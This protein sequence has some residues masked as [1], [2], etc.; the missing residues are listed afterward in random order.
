ML[1]QTPRF[2]TTQ[3]V[4]FQVAGFSGSGVISSVQ[5]PQHTEPVYSITAEGTSATFQVS[6]SQIF[7]IDKGLLLG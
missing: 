3:R 7:G 5:L 2:K 1:I 6:E 4:R